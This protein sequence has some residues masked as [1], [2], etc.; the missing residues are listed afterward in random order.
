MLKGS[1][2]DS[3]FENDILGDLQRASDQASDKP[4]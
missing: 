4:T 3:F 2:L 1:K